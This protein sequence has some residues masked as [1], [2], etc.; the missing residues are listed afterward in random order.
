MDGTINCMGWGGVELNAVDGTVYGC[1]GVE[2]TRSETKHG[3]SPVEAGEN[4]CCFSLALVA[5]V[6]QAH[7]P[8]FT[9]VYAK[10]ALAPD[11]L[12]RT[13]AAAATMN[14]LKIHSLLLLALLACPGLARRS[15][16]DTTD[17]GGDVEG[18]VGD[19]ILSQGVQR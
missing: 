4:S 14:Q 8:V 12:H 7:S 9:C 2:L 3:E 18:Y 16:D 15:S 19:D 1:G 13:A 6:P 10:R 17:I 11:H 5:R